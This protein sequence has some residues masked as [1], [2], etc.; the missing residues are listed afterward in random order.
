[1]SNVTPPAD[2]MAL[3]ENESTAMELYAV[4]K[5]MP[6]EISTDDPNDLAELAGMCFSTAIHLGGYVE[7]VQ[8]ARPSLSA[9]A[10]GDDLEIA[11]AALQRF[12]D[13]F[14]E[15]AHVDPST[16]YPE[17]GSQEDYYI[18]LCAALDAVKGLQDVPADPREQEYEP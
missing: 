8:A 12:H 18:E 4:L 15:R 7:R 17:Y 14:M 3:S 9:Q 2:L 11:E 6:A 16:G 13:K 10:V 1:M 5:Q